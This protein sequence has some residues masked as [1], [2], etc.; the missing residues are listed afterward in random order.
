[1]TPQRRAHL[2]DEIQ[3]VQEDLDAILNVPD[4]VKLKRQY[5]ET[6]RWLKNRISEL[7]KQL[8]QSKAS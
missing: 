4:G 1:M 2:A 6:V 3:R 7:G 5:F 8:T